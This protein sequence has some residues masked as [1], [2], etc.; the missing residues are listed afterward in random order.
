MSYEEIEKL[1]ES[2]LSPV[3]PGKGP[4]IRFAESPSQFLARHYQPPARRNTSQQLV[5]FVFIIDSSHSWWWD[6]LHF[7]LLALTFPSFIVFTPFSRSSLSSICPPSVLVLLLLSFGNI[8]SQLAVSSVSTQHALLSQ[9]SQQLQSLLIRL[10]P[11][12]TAVV[13]MQWTV[14]TVTGVTC[15]LVF[16][17]FTHLGLIP[18]FNLIIPN[19]TTLF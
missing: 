7:L 11:T 13:I 19:P 15:Q 9:W 8:P 12:S 18:Q 10:F 6:P 4:L 14:T 3:Q 5:C 1:L 16:K 2:D 17:K